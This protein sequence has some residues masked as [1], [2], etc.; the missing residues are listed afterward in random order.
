[1]KADAAIVS[2]RAGLTARKGSL[3]WL[4]SPLHCTGIMSTTRIAG[5]GDCAEVSSHAIDSVLSAADAAAS[6]RV[7]RV[8][9]WLSP[10]PV[11][12]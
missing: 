4:V 3:S 6:N 8:I 2:G 11:G 5:V 1:V 12:P 7:M 10:G 9:S